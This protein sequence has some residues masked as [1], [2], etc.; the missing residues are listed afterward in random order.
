MQEVINHTYVTIGKSLIKKDAV[1]KATGQSDFT[2]DLELPGMLFGAPVRSEFAHAKILGINIDRVN[3]IPGVVRVITADDVPGEIL[4]GRAILDQPVICRDKV[5]YF[6]DVVA[7]VIAENEPAAHLAADLVEV[8]Y[9]PLEPLTDPEKAM[10]SDA[11]VLHHHLSSNVLTHIK[12]RKGDI[13]SGFGECDHI[14]QDRFSTGF[15]DHL[16]LETECALASPR[17]D[18]GIDV[19]SASD[20]PFLTR[21]NIARVLGIPAHDVHYHNQAIGASFGS[22]KDSSFD[23]CSRT[24]LLSYLCGRPVKMRYS[25]RESLIGKVKRHASIVYNKLGCTED[26]TLRACEVRVILDTG[27]YSAKGDNDWG[28]PNIAAIFA[29]GPYEI[30][31]V[32]I[33]VYAV[34]TNNPFAGAMR[35]FGSPQVLFAQ[36]SQVDALSRKLKMDPFLFRRKN[37]F[38]LGSITATGHVLDHSVGIIPTIT[39]TKER[40]KETIQTLPPPADGSKRG[41]GVASGWYLTGNGGGE[42]FAQAFLFLKKDGSFELRTGLCEVGQGLK[43]AHSQICAEGLGISPDLVDIPNGDTDT[44][45][46]SMN[47]GASRGTTFG[48]NAILMA[49]K[50]AQK[51][52]LEL[53]SGLLC[54]PPENLIWGGTH[55]RYKSCPDKNISVK[56][57]AERVISFYDRE[58]LLVGQGFWKPPS[59]MGMHPDTGEGIPMHVYTYATH[60]AVADVDQETGEVSFQCF[61]A[62]QDVGKAINPRGVINQLEGSVVMGLGMSLTEELILDKGR[63]LYP[64]LRHYLIPTASDTPKIDCIIVEEPNRMGPFGAKGIG[65][66]CINPVAAAVGNAIY[67]ATGV[68]INSLPITQD[69]IWLALQG[70]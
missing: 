53:A 19:W 10:E 36:E 38:A 69:K 57:I 70:V 35:G 30:P 48:G 63:I 3:T 32:K 52:L 65:E 28:V 49:A 62:S 20:H 66:A 31:N 59:N 2:D 25:M 9:E 46:H 41:I 5:R 58:K 40:L 11:P 4:M 12:V 50:G 6:G 34:H 22:R 39:K 45:P 13:N 60:A 33:D 64:S 55:V 29:T 16:P 37:A 54:E 47:T 15:I 44:D 14:V 23:V 21:A 17:N 67:S 18:G 27:A 8:H 68:R 24:A 56:E 1:S 26:G 7:M 43:T 61:I 42:E 51:R